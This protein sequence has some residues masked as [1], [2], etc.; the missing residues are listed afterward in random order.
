[1]SV[2]AGKKYSLRK[3]DG[4]MIF[5]TAHFTAE[6]ESVLHSGIYSRELA[7]SIAAGGLLIFLLLLWSFFSEGKLSGGMSRYGFWG[8]SS[9]LGL[10]VLFSIL[11]RIYVF[12]SGYLELVFDRNTGKAGIF[13]PGLLKKKR[14]EVPMRDIANVLI[15]SKKTGVENPEGVE[16][17]EKISL[18]HGMAI[19]GFGE[20]K[21]FYQIK[22]KFA[23]GSD[24]IIFAD[25]DMQEALAAHEEITD[26]LGIRN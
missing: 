25:T 14:D 4:M 2:G 13:S 16:F 1:L 19:P 20:E 6:R 7:A 26:F 9:A 22:L 12:K 17:V 15:E 23:D 10:F 11:F 18:Q 5:R 21:T 8:V 24:R 3:T